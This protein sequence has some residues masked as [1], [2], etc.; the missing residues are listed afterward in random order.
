MLATLTVMIGVYIVTRMIDTAFR[1]D[2][3]KLIK[4]LAVVTVVVAIFGMADV[5]KTS[6]QTAEGV[7]DLQR[8]LGVGA[9]VGSGIFSGSRSD[10]LDTAAIDTIE[11]MKP[12]PPAMGT[13][14]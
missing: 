5:V 1:S 11:A 3:N 2:R 7:N 6:L 4:V 8:S 14:P 13:L 12:P 9:P 10:Y